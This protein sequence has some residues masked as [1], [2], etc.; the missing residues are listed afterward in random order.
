MCLDV[1]RA[2]DRMPGAAAVLLAE[3]APGAAAD[4]RL[5]ELVA[6]I[7][8]RIADR[9]AR[10]EAEA[11]AFTRDLILALQAA[12]LLRSAP[13]PVAE[14]FCASRLSGE[15]AGAFGMLPSGA[16]LQAIIARAAPAND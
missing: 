4:R 8:R 3:L 1:L 12:L 16:P 6:R 14:A 7:E 11:R 13:T 5:R 9:V 10:D 2:L 15:A